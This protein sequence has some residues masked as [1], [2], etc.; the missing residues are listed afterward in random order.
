MPKPYPCRIAP[1][2][3]KS[4]A[5]GPDLADLLIQTLLL[6]GAWKELAERR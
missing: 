3:I 6:L 5:I 1:G 2:S 4:E